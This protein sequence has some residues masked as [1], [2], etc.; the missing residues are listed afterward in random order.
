MDR[1]ARIAAYGARRS[2][3]SEQG[4]EAK[5]KQYQ[6]LVGAISRLRPRIT[7]LIKTANACLDNGIR[8]C[9]TYVTDTYEMGNFVTNSVTH[10]VGFVQKRLAYLGNESRHFNTV[11]IDNGGACGPYH[12][13]TNGIDSYFTTGGKGNGDPSLDSAVFTMKRFVAEF[14]A[15]EA[16]FYAYVDSIVGQ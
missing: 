7:E 10:K 15:F 6:E 12:F 11:G 5:K 1:M 9:G 8:V 4:E 13:R 16:A 3:N 2:E 14:D